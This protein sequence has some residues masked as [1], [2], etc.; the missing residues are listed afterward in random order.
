M[1]HKEYDNKFLDLSLSF[2]LL[3]N[4]LRLKLFRLLLERDMCVCELEAIMKSEQ[5]RISHSLRPL[6][7]LKIVKSHYEGKMVIYSL[8]GF[9]YESGIAELVEKNIDLSK[10]DKA[11]IN[12]VCST[13]PRCGLTG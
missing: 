9:A 3:G 10:R 6:K 4:P 2:K 11:L 7:L 13:S 1:K 12:A 8:D 5:S